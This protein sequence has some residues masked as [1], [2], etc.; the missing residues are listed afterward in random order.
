MASRKALISDSETDGG[1]L[2]IREDRLYEGGQAAYYA[3]M[4]LCFHA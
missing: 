2:I 1:D 4:L 3:S